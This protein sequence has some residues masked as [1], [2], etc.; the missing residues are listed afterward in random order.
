MFSL[1]FIFTTFLYI[2]NRLFQGLFQ[3][4]YSKDYYMCRLKSSQQVLPDDIDKI[5]RYRKSHYP[6]ENA[7]WCLKNTF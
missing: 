4:E 1:V 3:M 5:T 7:M 6:S 2:T